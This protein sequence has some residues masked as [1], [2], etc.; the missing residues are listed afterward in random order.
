MNNRLVHLTNPRRGRPV[1]YRCATSHVMRHRASGPTKHEP[2]QN[3]SVSD[4][5]TCPKNL[6]QSLTAIKTAGNWFT[7]L[8]GFPSHLKVTELGFSALG[9]IIG[10]GYCGEPI[11]RPNLRLSYAHQSFPRTTYIMSPL[12][13]ASTWERNAASAIPCSS[14]TAPTPLGRPSL[15]QTTKFERS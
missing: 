7:G 5:N 4:S 2:M 14:G 15:N 10:Q 6:A 3:D 12:P 11:A 13:L 1:P 8:E 9:N